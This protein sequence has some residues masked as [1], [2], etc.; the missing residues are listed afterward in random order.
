MTN[1]SAD[2]PTCPQCAKPFDRRS[3]HG[4]RPTYCSDKCRSA[5]YR[6]RA[7]TRN[8]SNRGAPPDH[9]ADVLRIGEALVRQAQRL[10]RSARFRAPGNPL[11][12]LQLY[13][14]LMRDVADFGAVAVRQAREY[15][16]S[17]D[18]IGAVLSMTG[19]AAR[20]RWPEAKVERT[21]RQRELRRTSRGT[22]TEPGKPSHTTQPVPAPI[23]NTAGGAPPGPH[24]QLAK[25]L[26]HLQ[27][28][29]NKSV[30]AIAREI[31]VSPSYIS[32]LLIGERRPSWAVATRFIQACGGNPEDVR[33]LWDKTHARQPPPA[34]PP[35]GEEF[36]EA[37]ATLQATLRGMYLAAAEPDPPLLCNV[38]GTNL[39]PPQV[40]SLLNTPQPQL[41]LHWPAIDGLVTALRGQPDEV[42][43]LWERMKAASPYA[44]PSGSSLPIPY[45]PAG[46]FG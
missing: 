32:R 37:A 5:A 40:K 39:T 1:P 29:S 6:A 9:D 43:P 3:S 36:T 14:N 38:P 7:A 41:L 22:Q 19:S 35:A 16:A 8:G 2:R 30:R 23:R 10:Q 24:A 28:T 12:V 4:R 17:W 15:G 42:R 33:P 20:S 27:R 34:M 21:L 25:A 26:S 13:T 46:S 18:Q 31:S 11:E 45:L 44:P